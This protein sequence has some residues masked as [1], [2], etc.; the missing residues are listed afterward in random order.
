MAA[1]DPDSPQAFAAH[2]RNTLLKGFAI[3]VGVLVFFALA[4]RW[5]DHNLHTQ[6]A[7]DIAQE[8][9]MSAT[10]KAERLAAFAR[11]DFA[12][13]C[14]ATPAGLE[15]LRQSLDEA[16]IS[17]QFHRLQWSLWLAI[18][19][20]AILTGVTLAT[21]WLNRRARAST[22]LLIES[23]RTAWRLSIA[24]ALAKVVLLIPLLAYGCFE[25]ATLASGSYFPKLILVV[26]VGGL[27][28]LW[29]AGSILIKPVPLEFEVTMARAIA[30]GEAP[31]LWADVR[32]AAARLGTTPPDHILVGMQHNFYVT[33]LAVI[34]QG[35]RTEGRTLYL[36][37]PLMQQLAPDEVMA[38]IGH[39]LGHFRGDD[40]R[41]TREFYPMHFK[42]NATLQ[43]MASSGWVGWTSVHALLFFHWS[44]SST[45]QA[46]SRERELLADRA[47]ADLTSPGVMGRALVKVQVFSEAFNRTL[48]GRA[49]N[50]FAVP[51]AALVR[52]ELVP[53]AE[54]WTQLF[55]QKAVH[56][57]DSH[58]PLRVRLEALGQPTDAKLAAAVATAET[59]PAYM[60]WFA[61]RDDLFAGIVGEALNAVS[62][63]RTQTADYSTQEGKE[64]LDKSFPEVCWPT[65]P[66][67]LWIKLGFCGLGTLIA[68]GLFWMVDEWDVRSGMLVLAALCA[69]PAVLQWRRHH[70]GEFTLR[71][72]SIDYTGW[73]R[74][75][76]FADVAQVT[77]IT[78][79]GSITL[80]FYLKASAS[81]IWR[82]S[83]FSWIRSK[84]VSLPLGLIPGKQKETLATIHRYFARLPA[85]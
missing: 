55:E 76:V 65:R 58:P 78:S 80:T 53:R 45:E 42:A 52:D 11:V 84:S 39:E 46:M 23:Y 82:Y 54:F 48:T 57:L 12:E 67:G 64:L 18:L 28:A 62:Q 77:T 44:F 83:P 37:H 34:Y 9:S 14:N 75:L 27:I 70:G 85:E 32:A 25:L 40:T 61:G 16:G 74:P 79:Y 21:F 29:R 50:P 33:E 81:G 73:H 5:L 1:V 6:I 10:T 2:V 17:G 30:P 3:P 31:G 43:A 20:M 56:P 60:R 51:L 72:D 41:I 66:T 49:E 69:T 15:G 35:G 36:S 38:I 22:A 4:P 13:V 47:A 7:A 8:G 24:A 63:V 19:L 68:L 26:V 71:A 59:E